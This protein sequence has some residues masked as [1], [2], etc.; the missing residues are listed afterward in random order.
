MVKSKTISE[1]KSGLFGVII[2][3]LA[4]IILSLI[5]QPENHRLAY[6]SKQYIPILR[7]EGYGT[8][9]HSPDTV[10]RFGGQMVNHVGIP[11]YAKESPSPSPFAT[12]SPSPN[13]FATTNPSPSPFATATPSPT[14]IPIATSMPVVTGVP[15]VTIIP[16]ATTS[17]SPTPGRGPR[18]TIT[19]INYTEEKLKSISCNDAETKYN[20]VACKNQ[21]YQ[22]SIE[23]YKS[24]MTDFLKDQLY[25]SNTTTPT[26]TPL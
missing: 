2:G 5:L 8:Q 26:P 3:L 21:R 25:P 4:I 18:P 1:I 17:P 15:G 13:P 24:K 12:T 16:S 19:P 20:S 22:K 6:L 14:G 23:T 7:R 10:D 11:V 9:T